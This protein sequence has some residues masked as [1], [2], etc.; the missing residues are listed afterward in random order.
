MA[1]I[2]LS[3]TEQELF[4]KAKERNKKL[5]KEEFLIMRNK[6]LFRSKST[7]IIVVHQIGG[8]LIIGGD[9]GDQLSL[10]E[11]F[12]ENDQGKG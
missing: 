9:T 3:K 1:K 10:K 6:A 7:T 8:I 11:N 12:K 4:D 2:K 5:T